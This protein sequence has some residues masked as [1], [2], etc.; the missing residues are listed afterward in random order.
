[1]SALI[2]LLLERRSENLETTY[3]D[4]G[5]AVLK[6]L[7]PWQEVVLDLNDEI[8]S[9][10]QGYASFDYEQG[11]DKLVEIVKVCLCVCVCV[12]VCLCVPVSVR[13]WWWVWGG[14]RS[15]GPE[16]RVANTGARIALNCPPGGHVAQR[17]T[18]RRAGVRNPARS[19][20]S[21]GPACVPETAQDDQAAAVRGRH[22]GCDRQQ[23]VHPLIVC[24]I[25][26]SVYE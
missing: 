24:R 17:Q 21:G 3:L 13:G 20:A 5:R 9:L 2:N 12:C 22:S 16:S 11:P 7:I 10:T 23:G 1:M 19:G 18:A 6:F 25:Y 26:T 4:D 14:G 8:K 15:V